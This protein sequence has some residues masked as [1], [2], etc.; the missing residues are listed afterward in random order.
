MPFSKNS[1]F[2]YSIR[3]INR[4]I[5]ERGNQLIRFSQIAWVGPEEDVDESKIKYDLRR[6][7]TEQ[8]GT[9]RMLKG[10]SFLSNN[11]PHELANVLV[12]ENFGDTTK[13]LESI[14]TRSDF[15]D[16]VHTVYGDRIPD[17]EYID[18]REILK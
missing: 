3:G 15:A 1:E 11:G 13:I 5:E 17:T 9:E 6:F 12:E 4:I 18:L 7:V 14:K 2:K 10:V 8:D 16:A